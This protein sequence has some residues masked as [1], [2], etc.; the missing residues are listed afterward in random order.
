M[1]GLESWREELNAMTEA[2]RGAVRGVGI[3]SGKMIDEA[4][5]GKR[6]LPLAEATAQPQ[7]GDPTQIPEEESANRRDGTE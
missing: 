4:P 5:F 2:R 1:G 7:C 3:D 6:S